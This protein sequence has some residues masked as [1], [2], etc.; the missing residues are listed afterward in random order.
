MPDLQALIEQCEEDT[1]ACLDHLPLDG[2]GIG[3]GMQQ[4]LRMNL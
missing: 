1:A 2:L 4:C 3:F